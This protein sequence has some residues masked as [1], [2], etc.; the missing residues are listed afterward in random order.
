MRIDWNALFA[1]LGA[2]AT[3]VA[4]VA[5]IAR[6]LGTHWLSRDIEAYRAALKREGDAEIEALKRSSAL[7]L[8]AFRREQ[9]EA[10]ERARAGIAAAGQRAERVRAEKER[11]A[12]PIQEAT[13][14]LQRRLDN[15]Q[16]HQAWPSLDPDFKPDPQDWPIGHDY[17][18]TSTV[19]LFAQFF[20][21]QTLLR[22][23]VRQDLFP[24]EQGKDAF[25]ALLRT[26]DQCLNSWPLPDFTAPV[27]DRDHPVFTLQQR[28]IGEACTTGAP[29]AEGCL[30][31]HAFLA[32]W[33]DAGFR[34]R[35][36]PLEAL[37]VGLAPQTAT[38]WERIARLRTRL[39]E[40]DAA[41]AAL[42]RTTAA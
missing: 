32:L 7:D 14:G 11:W 38:R 34:Q 24:D 16:D 35:T 4:A 27:G 13:R 18:L 5:W 40:I 17:L 39:Q 23:T 3:L 31:Y 9:Q 2:T 42:L 12:N 6:S 33:S 10:L 41:C 26:A 28:A 25:F 30:G 22:R 20:C 8:E 1:Q 36:A 37:L 29:G 15:I 21:L 19:F